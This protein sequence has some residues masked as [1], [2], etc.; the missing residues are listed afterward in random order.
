MLEYPGEV[1]QKAYRLIVAEGFRP[2]VVIDYE[3]EAYV[4]PAQSTRITFD[5]NIRASKEVADFNQSKAV[6]SG[7]SGEKNVVL[8]VK[9]NE[10]LPL[11]IKKMLSSSQAL[12]RPVSKYCL[13]RKTVT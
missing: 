1:A 2:S 3:R 11:F 8:E 10:R 9:Y 5:R 13:A 12:C 6:Y 4:L 7:V